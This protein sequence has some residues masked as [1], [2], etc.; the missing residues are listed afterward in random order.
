M[1]NTTKE[2][3]IIIIGGGIAGLYKAYQILT[4]HK[5]TQPNVLLLE[6]TN[7]LGGRIHTYRDTTYKNGIEAGAGRFH[8]GHKRLIKLIKELGLDHLITN[9]QT[10]KQYIPSPNIPI[11]KHDSNTYINQVIQESK[12]TPISILQKQTFLQYASQ[13]LPNDKPN[14]SQVILN[15]FGYSAELTD[16][17]A[18]DTIQLIE[19]HYNQSTYYGLKGGI[20]QIVIKLVEI[21]KQY[22]NFDYHLR[23]P[24]IKIIPIYPNPTSMQ[25]NPPTMIEIKTP[26]TTY[27][28]KTCICAIIKE[29]LIQIPIF[30]HAAKDLN[31][32][33]I[34]NLPLCRIYTK[35]PKDPNTNEVWFQG[36]K[37]MTTNTNLRYIIPI[38]PQEGT[39][40]VSYTD[41]TYADYWYRIYNKKGARVLNRELQKELQKIFP[42]KKI[43][44][45]THTK[46][47]YWKHGVAYYQPGFDSTKDI[48]KIRQPFQNI[49]IFIYGENYSEKNPQWIEGALEG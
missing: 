48:K 11:P 10:T 16:M 42:D 28:A 4:K 33:G 34:K 44:T 20:E 45:P 27:T 14:P 29:D 49:P 43:P 2:Y 31:L 18:Y 13:V 35:F 41:N 30:K 9:I 38:N 37:K 7:R 46:M 15:S 21:L 36:L 23:E 24:A 12:H 32:Q 47:F 8:K 5:K 6:S 39:M 1:D 17:N 22:P 26:K 25:T 40:M 19:N 3:D